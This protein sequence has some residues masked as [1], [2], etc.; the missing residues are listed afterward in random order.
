MDS[1][2]SI[3]VHVD[4]LPRSR[5]R[6]ELVRTLARRLDA[7]V[8]ALFPESGS[9]IPETL[10]LDQERREQARTLVDE[11]QGA[12]EP[13][14]RWAELSPLQG[15]LPAFVR[16]APCRDLMVLGQYDPADSVGA[17]VPADFVASVLVDSGKPVLVLPWSGHFG[18]I[19]RRGSSP[20]SRC[21][22]RRRR[23][24][25]RCRCCN[26]RRRCA[27]WAGVATP[28]RRA[29]CCCAMASTPPAT[30]KGPTPATCVRRCSRVRLTSAPTCW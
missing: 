5:A 3:L 19:G 2:A 28:S 12:G 15:V 18:D 20:G 14:L 21:A 27:W 22:R 4:A 11:V 13:H 10:R 17:G 7:T 30:T 1:L 16:E 26:P 8:T 9:F 6:L 25:R 23:C 24:P 29:R